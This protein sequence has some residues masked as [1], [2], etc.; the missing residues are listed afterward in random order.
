MFLE[1][2]IRRQHSLYPVSWLVSEIN[3][4]N[5][6][7]ERSVGMT[8]CMKGKEDSLPDR[9]SL[10]EASFCKELLTKRMDA[11]SITQ[12]S[13]IWYNARSIF[14]FKKIIGLKK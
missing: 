11:L 1:P 14:F 12:P 5:R 2:Q 9:N 7:V 4:N 10:T 8:L 13:L 3:F 6:L